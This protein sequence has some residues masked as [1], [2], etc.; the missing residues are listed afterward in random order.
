MTRILRFSISLACFCFAFTSLFAQEFRSAILGR[1]T[2]PQDAVVSG[3]KITAT[4]VETGTRYETVSGS[5]GQYSLPYLAPGGYRVTAEMTGFKRYVR[6][7]LMVGANERVGL[8]IRIEVGAVSDTVTVNA[9]TPLIQTAS[10]SVGGVINQRQLKNMPMNGRSP[11]GLTQLSYIAVFTGDMSSGT[12]PT[13]NSRQSA[14]SLGGAP[15]GKAEF[16]L[17]GAANMDSGGLVAYIPIADAVQE[18]KVE[19]FQVDAAYGHTGSGTV[20]LVTKSGTNSLHGSILWF[21]QASALAANDF[22][23][24]A[25]ATGKSV[26]SFNQYGLTMGGPVVVP[27]VIN[28]RNKLFFFFGYEGFRTRGHGNQILTVPTAAERT[29]DFSALLNLTNPI[30]IYDPLTGVQQ[31][32]HVVRQAFT[33]NTI[34]TNRLTAG[35]Q[36][37]LSFYAQPNLPGLPDGENNYINLLPSIDDYHSAIGR[38]DINLSDRQKLFF[39]YRHNNRMMK[40]NDYFGTPATGATTNEWNWGATLDHVYTVTPTLLVNSRLN[41]T[42]KAELRWINGDGFD[43]T[44]S[45][46]RSGW[47]HSR[48]KWPSRS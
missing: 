32:S 44:H 36:K 25:S 8:D 13:D 29:G 12:K 34:P 39:D 38:L 9:E 45:G 26:Q 21:N 20:S 1:I 40:N 37:L 28:G 31:G 14:L 22:F 47:R 15:A 5:D 48:R 6:D 2:D 46:S 7:G 19:A 42:R 43:F 41:W 17:D 24:N 4:Q 10:A 30:K 3:V 18:V 23:R 33:N 16:L 11:L 35:G 27:K